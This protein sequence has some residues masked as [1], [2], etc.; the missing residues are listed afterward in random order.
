MLFLVV[1]VFWILF[2]ITFLCLWA[3]PSVSTHSVIKN[4]SWVSLCNGFGK[5]LPI[6]WAVF[7]FVPSFVSQPFFPFL[8]L[9]SCLVLSSVA[10]FLDYVAFAPT[11]LPSVCPLP[12]WLTSM[13]HLSFWQTCAITR[14]LWTIVR[15][16]IKGVISPQWPMPWQ[17]WV[18]PPR[19]RSCP[20]VL[21]P[22]A[23]STTASS[24]RPVRRQSKD[25]RSD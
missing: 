2:P 19:C 22:S 16:P 14:T 20:V 11:F 24:A 3:C 8:Y 21:G 13:Q 1:N 9:F 5:K 12:S 7:F 15:L 25:S 10:S 23:T 6:F 18:P 4:S 17:G